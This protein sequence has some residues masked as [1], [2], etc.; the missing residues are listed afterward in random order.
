MPLYN[1]VGNPLPPLQLEAKE[2]E[3]LW[4]LGNLQFPKDEKRIFHLSPSDFRIWLYMLNPRES[5]LLC[6][7]EKISIR[8]QHQMKRRRWSLVT[9]FLWR[10]FN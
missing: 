7:T 6:S 1:E 3:R 4:R 8:I 10:L 9:D 5:L 2:K